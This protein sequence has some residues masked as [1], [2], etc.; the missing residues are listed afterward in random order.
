MSRFTLLVATLGL[1]S[2]SASAGPA[3]NVWTYGPA[4]ACRAQYEQYTTMNFGQLFNSSTSI[5]FAV[6]CALEGFYNPQNVVVQAYDGATDGVATC[7]QCFTS[8]FT[9]YCGASTTTSTTGTGYSYLYPTASSSVFSGTAGA[10][11][12]SCF[13]PAGSNTYGV[14]KYYYSQY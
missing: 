6:D 5:G 7:Y 3:V 11:Y 14:A 8:G 2:A 12:V 10:F 1:L 9:V 13:L 4:S